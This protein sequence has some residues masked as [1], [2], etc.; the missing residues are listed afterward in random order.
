MPL[1][2]GTLVIF[3]HHLIKT[4]CCLR[5]DLADASMTDPSFQNEKLHTSHVQYSGKTTLVS[6]ELYDGPLIP[7]FCIVLSVAICHYL[8]CK[9]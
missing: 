2:S 8:L 4:E 9:L 1:C 6:L 3:W 5:Y 7:I